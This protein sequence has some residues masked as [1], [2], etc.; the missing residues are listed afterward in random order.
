MLDIS[1]PFLICSASDP[2][3]MLIHTLYYSVCCHFSPF[4]KQYFNIFIIVL[5]LE[6]EFNFRV[7]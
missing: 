1:C 3:I 7:I 5:V 4:L 6:V 2:E